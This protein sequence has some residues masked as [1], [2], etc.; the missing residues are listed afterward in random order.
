MFIRK[1]IIA[2]AAVGTLAIA[3]PSLAQ[4]KDNPSNSKSNSGVVSSYRHSIST[5]VG[6]TN[7]TPKGS[8]KH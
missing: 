1:S 7:S 3:A 4:A 8:R 2:M 5:P 6:A